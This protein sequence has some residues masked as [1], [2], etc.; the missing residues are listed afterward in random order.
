MALRLVTSHENGSVGA[1]PFTFNWIFRYFRGSEVFRSERFQG[2]ARFL[3]RRLTDQIGT[4]RNDRP[5]GFFG[6]L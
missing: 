3:V 1:K 5:E 2:N 6:S 4:P